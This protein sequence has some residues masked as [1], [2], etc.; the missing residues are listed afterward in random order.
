MSQAEENLRSFLR[1][2]ESMQRKGQEAALAQEFQEIKNQTAVFRQAEDFSTE[3]GRNQENIK[4]NRYKDILPYDQTR[5]PLTLMVEEGQTNYI[6]ASFIQGLDNQRRYIATQG[7]L[8]DTMVDFWRM[9]WEYQV[10]VIVMACRE[11]ELGKKKCERYWPLDQEPSSFGPFTVFMVEKNM[12]N[13]EVVFRTLRVTFQGENRDIY[14]FQYVAWPDRGIPDSY[15][16]FLEMIWLVRLYQGENRVPLCIHCSA[17]CGRTGVICTVEYIQ[18]LIYNQRIPSNF[19]IFQIVLEMRKQRPSAVQT[20]EQYE[21]VYHAV[22]EMFRKKLTDSIVN[23]ENLKENKIPFYDDAVSLRTNRRAKPAPLRTTSY[24][25]NTSVSAEP[26]RQSLLDPRRTEDMNDTYA[27]VNKFKKG[28]ASSG[29]GDARCQQSTVQYDNVPVLGQGNPDQVVY[30]SV[31]PRSRVCNS[32]TVQTPP[33][34]TNRLDG[35]QPVQSSYCLA[36]PPVPPEKPL[37]NNYAPDTDT[38]EEGGTNDGTWAYNIPAY[39][40]EKDPGTRRPPSPVQN[41]PSKSNKLRQFFP[42]VL[43]SA[44]KKAAGISGSP[45]VEEYE[46]VPDPTRC[47]KS[48]LSPGNGLGFNYRIGRPKGPRDPPAEWSR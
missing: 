5:V 32:P 28:T 7:P 2:V 48:S 27:V 26:V 37:G 34:D 8:K 11:V 12:P 20:K 19:S 38:R 10:K 24:S 9:V 4:K 42:M 17:G 46:D 15:D 16:C 13:T 21:F 47:S 44:G 43:M 40:T 29:L 36:G 30:S 45:S 33:L 22:V 35:S 1:R 39:Q 31:R 6:N 18:E 41:S 23:Y 25:R 3:V 14:H